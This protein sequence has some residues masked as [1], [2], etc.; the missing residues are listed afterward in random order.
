MVVV[1]NQ[2][3]GVGGVLELL[4]VLGSEMNEQE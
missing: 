2:L 3:A 4:C 1:M